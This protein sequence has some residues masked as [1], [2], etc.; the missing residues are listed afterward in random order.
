MFRHLQWKH[1]PE[2]LENIQPYFTKS[3]KIIDESEKKLF[4]VENL[5]QIWITFLPEKMGNA[6]CFR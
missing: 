2:K 3:F 6:N 4:N 5:K 1:L